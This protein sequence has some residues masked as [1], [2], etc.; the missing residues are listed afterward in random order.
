M[1]IVWTDCHLN[2]I[3]L[4]VQRFLQGTTVSDRVAGL[5]AVHLK[6]RRPEAT[7]DMEPLAPL[8]LIEQYSVSK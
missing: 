6:S 2:P 1:P 8:R 5:S 4:T 7:W 3:L